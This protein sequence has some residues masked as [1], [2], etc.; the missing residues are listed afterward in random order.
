[1]ELRSM[2]K[3]KGKWVLNFLIMSSFVMTGCSQG[4][5]FGKGSEKDIQAIEYFMED[6]R[7]YQ[8]E[9]EVP[10]FGPANE[11]LE[12]PDAKFIVKSAKVYNNPAE[13]GLTIDQIRKV[14]D[15]RAIEKNQKITKEVIM[16]A[17]IVI[18]DISLT[19]IEEIPNN[20]ISN[21]TLVELA[22]DNQMKIISAPCYF[23]E[24]VHDTKSAVD[25]YYHYTLEPEESMEFQIGFYLGADDY[26]LENLYLAD[27]GEAEA[28]R[29]HYIDMNLKGGL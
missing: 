11:E 18:L 14:D 5:F 25:G 24:G 2:K 13:F 22:E 1:M 29:I 15:Q 4:I 3:R 8:L 7:V 6:D 26:Q 12:N 21:F 17:P 10:Y 27:Q 20:N 19:E 9:K 16:E 23:S 28:E